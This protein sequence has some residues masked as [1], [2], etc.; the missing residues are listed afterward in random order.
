MAGKRMIVDATV[1]I[2]RRLNEKGFSV[3][4]G[5]GAEEEAVKEVKRTFGLSGMCEQDYTITIH[6]IKVAE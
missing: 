4:E 5:S 1:H 2:T 6:R 3:P